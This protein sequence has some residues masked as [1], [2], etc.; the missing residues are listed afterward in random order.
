MYD[1]VLRTLVGLAFVAAGCYCSARPRLVAAAILVVASL[2]G[3]GGAWPAAA[4]LGA[5]LAAVLLDEDGPALGAVTGLALGQGAL[6]LDWPSVT[7]VSTLLGLTAFLV[8]A[9]PALGHVHRQTRRLVVVGTVVVLGAVCVLGLLWGATALTVRNDLSTAVDHANAG[10]D[11]ARAGDTDIAA[12]RLDEARRVVRAGT[13]PTRCVVG[14]TDPR[15]SGSRA[16][17]APRCG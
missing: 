13:G 17:R 10:L 11:A 15:R 12:Q 2:L 8:V 1:A 9:V 4:A 6:R 16:E 14:A 5:S 3:S 7:G